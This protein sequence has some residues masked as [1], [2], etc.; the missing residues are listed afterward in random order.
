MAIIR[1][2]TDKREQYMMT[3]TEPDSGRKDNNGR[4]LDLSIT[5]PNSVQQ[6]VEKVFIGPVRPY[7][8]ETM[9]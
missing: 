5:P 3:R 4:E 9:N 6:N 8:E 7:L 2:Q 1:G